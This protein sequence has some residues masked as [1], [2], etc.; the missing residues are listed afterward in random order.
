MRL[1]E[2]QSNETEKLHKC[3]QLTQNALTDQ[4]N[5]ALDLCFSS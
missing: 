1:Y 2:M 4:V 3:I 5:F